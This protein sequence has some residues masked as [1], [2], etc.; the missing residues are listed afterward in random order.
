MK[1]TVSKTRA[2]WLPIIAGGLIGGLV[3]G[4]IGW[5]AGTV[6]GR[7]GEPTFGDLAGGL[8]G[9]LIGYTIGV[10]GGAFWIARNRVGALASWS[11]L[12]VAVLGTGVLLLLAEPL[13]LNLYPQI[14]GG[15]VVLSLPLLVAWWLHKP[16][17]ERVHKLIRS[18]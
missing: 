2:G 9:A 1:Q 12:L 5:G 14:W 8:L 13:R 16:Q 10:A 3:L 17:P 11:A 7:S 4:L 15:L 18:V 6:I